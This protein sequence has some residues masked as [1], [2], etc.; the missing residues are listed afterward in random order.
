MK[1][2]FAVTALGVAAFFGNVDKEFSLVPSAYAEQ[3]QETHQTT[4]VVKSVDQEKGRVTLAHD[5]VPTL[6]WPG[7]TMG[8]SVADKALL[9]NVEADEKVSF[10]FIKGE[11][12]K[13]LIT[14][15]SPI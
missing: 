11:G 15:I 8:F 14:E 7:M 9:E 6:K 4:G 10:T 13:F 2:L 3:S 12:G 1:K 5:P